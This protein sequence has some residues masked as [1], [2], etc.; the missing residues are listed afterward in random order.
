MMAS[1]VGTPADRPRPLP[2]GLGMQQVRAGARV[3]EAWLSGGGFSSGCPDWARLELA[4]MAKGLPA[5][6][7]ASAVNEWFR[8]IRSERGKSRG[9]PSVSYPPTP[10]D[11]AHSALLARLL[12]G[13][14]ALDDAP[15]TAFGCPWYAVVEGSGPFRCQV[16]RALTLAASADGS[17]GA[18]P[19]VA[20][21]QAL[22]TV[23]EELGEDDLLVRWRGR[24]ATYR[25]RRAED[26]SEEAGAFPWQLSRV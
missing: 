1:V 18:E 7:A 24:G 15:P 23:V 4:F 20:V 3:V 6:D 8:V 22:W 13:L 11:A 9:L 12:S 26:G 17:A 10:D 19:F 2:V 21:N 14:P 5:R 25:L 16:S